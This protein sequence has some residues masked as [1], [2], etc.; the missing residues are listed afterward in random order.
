MPE[1]LLFD[2]EALPACP[3][4][5]WAG[6]T[7]GTTTAE[8]V[9]LPSGAPKAQQNREFRRSGTT[10]TTRTTRD[11]PLRLLLREHRSPTRSFPQSVLPMEEATMTDWQRALADAF[12]EH[13]KVG[14]SG[15]SCGS[16]RTSVSNG[17]VFGDASCGTTPE[18]HV[19]PVV[20]AP[21]PERVAGREKAVGTA[22]NAHVPASSS[23]IDQW[24]QGLAKLNPT[25]PIR[26]FAPGRWIRLIDGGTTFL[27]AWGRT[28]AALGWSTLDVFGVH[29]EAPAARYDVMGLVPLLGDREL[30]AVEATHATM[31]MP[32]GSKLTYLRRR[33]PGAVPIWC[34]P[35]DGSDPENIGAATS[36]QSLEGPPQ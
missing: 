16:R 18:A 28:A 34:V 13:S 25:A 12:R 3:Y 21:S 17:A 30:T 9:V 35:I 20:P 26:G 14:G 19:V 27:D 7:T 8:E 23:S 29:P 24:R 11:T 1:A 6:G 22:V 36:S 10:G 31:R 2:G 32:T 5:C 33:R 15:G 4:V